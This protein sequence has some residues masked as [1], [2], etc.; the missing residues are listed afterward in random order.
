MKVREVM[1]NNLA[2]KVVIEEEGNIV[3]NSLDKDTEI[4]EDY[5]KRNCK[6]NVSLLHDEDTYP[7]LHLFIC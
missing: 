3:W 6:I 2:D 5:L 7:A 4:P 1:K